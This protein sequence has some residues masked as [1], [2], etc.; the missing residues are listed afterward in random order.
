MKE[1]PVKRDIKCCKNHSFELSCTLNIFTFSNFNSL[2]S[3]INITI[4]CQKS[5]QTN[6]HKKVEYKSEMRPGHF[7]NTNSSTFILSKI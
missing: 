4:G 7:K 5:V 2:V 1:N 3:N 6:L